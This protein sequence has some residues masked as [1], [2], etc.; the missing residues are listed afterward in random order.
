MSSAIRF[1]QLLLTCLA[2]AALAAMNLPT[3]VVAQPQTNG[4][5]MLVEFEKIEGLRHWEQEL[6]QRGLN[7]LVQ[8]QRD[9]IEKYPEDFAR[10]ALKDYPVTGVDAEKPFWDMPY[11]ALRRMREAKQAVEYAT[12]KPMRCLVAAILRTTK[13]P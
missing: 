8:A 7:A 3:R 2:F 10:L 9:V 1:F 12:H 11:G 13:T 4:L 6:D 5:I